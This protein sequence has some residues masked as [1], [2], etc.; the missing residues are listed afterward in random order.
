MSVLDRWQRFWFE[1]IPTH[2]YALLRIVFGA[3]GCITLIGLSDVST[4]WDPNG[5][6]PV[7]SGLGVKTFFL[8]HGLGHAAGLALYVCTLASFVCM[9]IG[10]ASTISVMLAMFLSVVQLAWNHLPLSGADSALRAFLFCLMWADCGSAWSVDAWIRG[11]RISAP[12]NQPTY[13]IAPL[14]L[15][16]FQI[17]LIYFNAGLWKLLNPYWRDGSAVHY[18]LETNVYHRFPALLPATLDW[19]I[20]VLTYGTLFWELAFAFLVL[21][22]PTRRLVI[23]LGILLHVGMLLTI[24]IGPFHW[25]MLAS[26]LAFLDPRTVST[27]GLPLKN[28]EP[29]PDFADAH[30]PAARS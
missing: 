28:Q 4:F 19:V 17:A 21:F 20:P 14:R 3:I 25:V 9:T 2:I 22:R 29:R 5:F 8:A 18:V 27:F 26:Y 30:M 13:A 7:G 11:S 23:V 1:P 10:F 12:A 24:E 15:I 16:R 6:V